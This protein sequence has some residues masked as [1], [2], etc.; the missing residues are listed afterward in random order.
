VAASFA[1]EFDVEGIEK[2]L[3]RAASG[4]LERLDD[5]IG[6]VGCGFGTYTRQYE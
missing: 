3:I 5:M 2:L 6:I 1:A 4:S